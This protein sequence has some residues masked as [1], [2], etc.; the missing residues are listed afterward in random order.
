MY[1]SHGIHVYPSSSDIK[2]WINVDLPIMNDLVSPNVLLSFM[3]HSCG[4]D[5]IH[6]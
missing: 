6:F 5:Y 3:G 1:L 4:I 2:K